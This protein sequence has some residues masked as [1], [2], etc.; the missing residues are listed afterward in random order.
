MCQRDNLEYIFLKS[1]VFNTN[2]SHPPN[3]GYQL[4]SPE[5]WGYSPGCVC[6]CVGWPVWSLGRTKRN[7]GD[8]LVRSFANLS[9]KFVRDLG[10]RKKVKVSVAPECLALCDPVDPPGSFVHGVL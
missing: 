5:T 4:L 1:L 8:S 10:G 6:V 9:K 3:S 2:I 7:F